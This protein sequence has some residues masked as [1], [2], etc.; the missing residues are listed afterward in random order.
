[1]ANEEQTPDVSRL[2]KDLAEA[3][4]RRA[5][6]ETQLREL[7]TWIAPIRREFGNPFFYSGPAHAR[8]ENAE[9]SAAHYTGQAS[10]EVV[11]QILGPIVLQLH[12]VTRE[13]IEIRRQLRELDHE[14]E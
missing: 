6:L 12:E 7:D 14:I 3:L 10:H 9:K 5:A 4:E 13:V 1:M 8:H 11:F 2:L